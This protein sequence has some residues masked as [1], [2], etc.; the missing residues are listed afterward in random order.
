MKS[1]KR[2]SLLLSS[3]EESDPL[4]VVVNLFDVAMVFAVALMVAMVM[5]MNMTEMFT[6]EDFTIVKNPGKDNMEIITREGKKIN[7][8]VPSNT[9]GDSQKRGKRIGTAYQL[10]NG[11]IIYLPE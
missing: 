10:E 7:K 1:K 8:Y 11:D 2:I 6:N 5:N 3:K 9:N 4:S